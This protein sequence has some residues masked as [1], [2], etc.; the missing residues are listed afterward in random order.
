MG[1]KPGEGITTSGKP[2]ASPFAPKR[3]TLPPIQTVAV[4][5]E[6]E[7]L[8]EPHLPPSPVVLREVAQAI[9]EDALQRAQAEAIRRE[10]A[11]TKRELAEEHRAEREQVQLSRREE[12]YRRLKLL[13]DAISDEDFLDIVNA[14]VARAAKGEF[15]AAELL[16]GY[17]LG[18]PV[19]QQEF[20]GTGGMPPLVIREVVVAR[21]MENTPPEP[22]PVRM[23]RTGDNG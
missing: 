16:L 3:R 2:K 23:R 7:L 22:E 18:K 19:Q 12:Q 4:P 14:L 11:P 21:T 6:E 15:K 10:I 8:P 5:Q 1:E 20:T 17:L 9:A 13:S